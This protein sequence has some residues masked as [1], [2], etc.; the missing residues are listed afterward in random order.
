[1]SPRATREELE[2][3]VA[4]IGD[5]S[6]S[7]AHYG[8]KGMKWGKRK[9]GLRERA[10]GARLDGIQRKRAVAERALNEKGTR[11][12]RIIN[13]P[14]KILMGKKSFDQAVTRRIADLDAQEE[15]IKTG[16]RTIMDRIEQSYDVTVLD[17]MV[18]RRD[19]KG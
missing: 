5:E 3:F 10:K 13:G 16:K 1:M 17:L 7:L 4:V 11:E 2:D 14:Q 18:S 12:E 8:I 15:R 19:N 9:G 6:A